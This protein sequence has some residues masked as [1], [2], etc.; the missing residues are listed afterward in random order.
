MNLFSQDFMVGNTILHY[1]IIAKLGEGGMG[2]IYKA[3]D[4]KLDRYVALKM[5]P[6]Q[7]SNTEDEKKRFIKE[8]K[9]ASSIS[10]H[11]VCTIYD[12]LEFENSDFVMQLFIVMEYVDGH[13]LR[14]LNRNLTIQE[15]DDIGIQIAEGLTAAHEKGIIHRDIK[16]ENI[17][18]RK[19]GRVQIMDFGLAK[20]Y[21][22]GNSSR[23]TKAGT[24]IGTL[25]YMSPEQVKGFDVDFRSDIFSTG[26][27]LYE[28]LTG[29]SPF[30]GVHDAAIIYKIVNLEV[31]AVSTLR[32]DVDPL[33]DLIVLKC[34][35]KEKEDRYQ[36]A[37]EL[38]ADLKE[39]KQVLNGRETSNIYRKLLSKARS[40]RTNNLLRLSSKSKKK[41]RNYILMSLLLV[42]AVMFLLYNFLIGTRA[43]HLNPEMKIQELVT[44]FTDVSFPSISA[45][46]NW[47]AFPAEDQNYRWDIYLMHSRLNEPRRVTND[48]AGY[49]NY[50]A[51]SPDGGQIIYTLNNNL[52]IVSSLGGAEKVLADNCYIS[53]WSPDGKRI[54]FIRKDYPEK[55]IISFWTIKPDGSNAVMKFKEKFNS[56]DDPGFSFSPDGNSL[57]WLRSFSGG[58]NEIIIKQLNNNKENILSED[59]KNIY[60][61]SW[62]KKGVILFS[63]NKEGDMNLYMMPESGGKAVQITKGS[64]P[65]MGINISSDLSKILYFRCINYSNM[66]IKNLKTN[67]SKQITFDE[68]LIT[69]PAF[70]PDHKLIAFVS[71]KS[72]A[73]LAPGNAIFIMDRYGNNQKQITSDSAE[74]EFLIF[75]PDGK[76]IAYTQYTFFNQNDSGNVYIISSNDGDSPRYIS[77]GRAYMWADNNSLVISKKNHTEIIS[78]N[79]QNIRNVFQDSTLAF[80]VDSG[81]IVFY[82]NLHSKNSGRYYISADGHSNPGYIFSSDKFPFVVINQ[83]NAYAEDNSNNIWRYNYLSGR[84]RNIGY[85]FDL[86]SYCGLGFNISS[87]DKEMIYLE[88]K[89]RSD[90]VMIENAFIAN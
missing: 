45:D 78:I 70:S 28:L 21:S 13:T 72:P 82:L 19:D 2:E 11:N 81:K 17:M 54:G 65:D 39:F 42:S 24:T 60:D 5:L 51:I 84:K 68:R 37:E 9:A 76:F 12:I 4:T 61:V 1:K 74:H 52:Y 29:E 58:Y 71:H 73:E 41:I 90:L 8:A 6:A 30:K 77:G 7:F 67:E 69:D 14:N 86:I 16:P 88:Q 40:K 55:G 62:T 87:D 35:E 20:L 49:I 27:V 26:A 33:L 46:G 36:S 57:A 63:S 23:L 44:S 47:I 48:S 25:D 18:L 79:G 83:N 31:P 56:G 80:P 3:L 22:A 43:I 53:K 50:A 75:S 66:W 15:I 59:K 38:T 89:R 34:L 10:H 32:K 64:G 85:F